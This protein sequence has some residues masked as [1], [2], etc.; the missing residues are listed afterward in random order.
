M[1]RLA[2]STNPVTNIV[3]FEAINM[4][5]TSQVLPSPNVPL[6]TGNPL[7]PKDP[8]SRPPPAHVLPKPS[9]SGNR[10]EST[11]SAPSPILNDKRNYHLRPSPGPDNTI[12][13]RIHYD[14]L[15]TNT[16]RPTPSSSPWPIPPHPHS[17]PSSHTPPQL[18][19]ASPAAQPPLVKVDQGSFP[20][21]RKALIAYYRSYFPGEPDG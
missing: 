17:R 13:H 21:Y 12:H 5:Q 1:S 2:T 19:P 3:A 20:V 6:H 4:P 10:I 11:H 14:R 9:L 16:P 7:S 15:D 18:P 8:N